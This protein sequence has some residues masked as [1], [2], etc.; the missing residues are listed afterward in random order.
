[1]KGFRRVDFLSASA[2]E[3]RGVLDD[4]RCV[5][6]RFDRV[7]AEVA[8]RLQATSATP[9]RDVSTSAQRSDL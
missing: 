5:R 3:L 7:E 6:A 9:E 1:M 8:R 4:I 2:A